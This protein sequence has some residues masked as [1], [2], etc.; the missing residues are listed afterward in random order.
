MSS[1]AT[2]IDTLTATLAAG[3]LKKQL[4]AV[5]ELSELDATGDRILIDFLKAELI[6]QD[7]TPSA[8]HGSAY[9][10]LCAS[11]SDTT[12]TFLYQRFPNGLLTPQSERGIDYSELQALL[13][14]QDYQSADKLTMQKLCEL[15]GEQAMQRKWVYFTEVSQFPVSDLQT[16][17]T[18]WRIYSED[19]FGWS[20]QHELW[21]RLGKD[22]ERLWT[23]LGWKSAEGAWTRY[24]ME[25][26]WD[27]SAPI[28]HLPLSNQLRGVRMMD[29]LLSHPAWTQ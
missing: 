2:G 6:G 23:Q 20:K 4:Q 9:Q 1:N 26:I 16:I 7:N 28:G 12:K 18:L 5:Y 17:D 8:I 3:S 15:A 27:L 25:F 11:E 19:R 29:S 14:K 21:T 13:V 24:P 10:R 22:W